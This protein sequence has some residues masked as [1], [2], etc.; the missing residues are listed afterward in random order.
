MNTNKKIIIIKE[1][2]GEKGEKIVNKAAG[3]GSL[4]LIAERRREGGGSKGRR[5]KR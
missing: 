2:D 3:A 4:G 1:G 5:G